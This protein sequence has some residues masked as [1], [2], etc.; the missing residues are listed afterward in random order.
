MFWIL[1]STAL[2]LFIHFVLIK[3]FTHWSR[4]NI[5]QSS[6]LFF[7][8]SIFKSFKNPKSF[9]EKFQD[10]YSSYTNQR[11]VAT[12]QLH[13]PALL[14]LEPDL[15]KQITVKDFD[16]FEDH[17]QIILNEP[18]WQKNLTALKGDQWR[19]MRATLSPSFTSS[20]MK[21][22]F[23]L[24]CECA[25]QFVDHFLKKNEETVSL[26]MKET[27]SRYT[28][29]V[30]AS[31]AFGIKCD[32]L[33]DPENEFYTKGKTAVN[34]MGIKFLLIFLFP[35]ISSFLGIKVFT[36]EVSQFF[37]KIIKDTLE[38]RERE[39]VV[40]L[41]MIHLLMQARKGKLKDESS[42]T[43]SSAEEVEKYK[44]LT[45]EDIIAQA[46]VFFLGGFDSVSSGMSFVAY[47]LAVNPDIQKRLQ[48]EIDETIHSQGTI[49]YDSL[50]KMKY[51]DMVISESLR[52]WPTT[53][54]TD[55]VCV[56]PYTIEPTQP[57]EKPI[58]LK[59]GDLMTIP[60]YAIQR[61]PRFYSDPDVFN[62]ERFS[63]ENK[64]S[65]NPYTYL[66]F[67]TGPRSC[68]GNRFAILEM[69]TIIFY[70][71]SKFD[72]V[73]VKKTVIPLQLGNNP[74]NLNAKDGF[75]L[76]LKPRVSA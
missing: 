55:R 59:E 9:A 18:L 13:I 4:R 65:I 2:V 11:Y 52:K 53:I 23:G 27:F 20:K 26:E 74:V 30:I 1:L 33:K 48:E 47:E 28:T 69:K 12:Y 56:K 39:G 42:N 36:A 32:S 63:E 43:E 35:R 62:P 57:G 54:A 29:D 51:L 14:L 49:T 46:L 68:I 67:G 7:W 50:M 40:R 60:I 44:T 58:H 17:N 24:M 10:L 71:L 37:S 5:P 73:T 70:V 76:G 19:E 6:V 72:I 8:K 15:I 3:P 25:Q 21:M 16:H 66:T 75:W 61:D 22:M 41:D 45:D 38:Y 64:S 31:V 34:F